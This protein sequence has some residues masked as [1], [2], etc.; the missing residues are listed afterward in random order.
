MLLTVFSIAACRKK[1]TVTIQAQNLTNLSDG[2]HYAGMKYVVVE[3]KVGAFENK[4][5]TVKEGVL[6]ENGYAS[7]DVRKHFNRTY[8]LGIEEPENTCYSEVTIKYHLKNEQSDVVN[9]NY[10][11]CGCLTLPRK[12]VNCE[13]PNDK[14]QLKYYYTNNPDV[15]FY[16]GYT[17]GENHDWN[18]V[19]FI[20]GCVDNTYLLNENICG[21]EV[22][23]GNYTIEW[24]VYRPSGTTT[25]IDYFT[26]AEN[27]T[28]T[29]VLEY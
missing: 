20:E 2:S 23:A 22:P 19:F 13:G 7:F 11:P 17:T 26:V 3:R 1:Y 29:Y 6:N 15:Y 10:A 25:G 18:D 5:K 21:T 14:M 8:D 12:N 16:K 9:F 28:T 27:D 4:Y 24:I